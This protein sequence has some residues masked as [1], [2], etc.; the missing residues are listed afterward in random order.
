V[1]EGGVADIRGFTHT[2]DQIWK[3]WIEMQNPRYGP[4]FYGENRTWAFASESQKR[5]WRGYLEKYGS[6]QI[7]Y[8]EL[9]NKSVSIILPPQ[10]GDAASAVDRYLLKRVAGGAPE[11]SDRW[12]REEVVP[13]CRQKTGV[14]YDPRTAVEGMADLYRDCAAVIFQVYRREGLRSPI[15]GRYFVENIDTWNISNEYFGCLQREMGSATEN[16]RIRSPSDPAG[17]K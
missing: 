2:Y 10:G 8:G 11:D 12:F 5:S 15:S 16:G 9:A 17:N 4:N 7:Y 3:P 14:S 13:H 6:P 1:V